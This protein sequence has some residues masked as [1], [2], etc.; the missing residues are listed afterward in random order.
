MVTVFFAVDE[1]RIG[2][3]FV[4]AFGS[5]DG[6]ITAVVSRQCGVE[7]QLDGFS[8]CTANHRGDDITLRKMCLFQFLVIALI[9]QNELVE[10]CRFG[11]EGRQCQHPVSVVDVQNLGNRTKIVSWI[12]FAVSGQIVSQAVMSVF[13]SVSDLIPQI[14]LISPGAVNYLTEN[15]LFYHI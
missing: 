15:T 2:S 12:I 3:F 14:M 11:S 5:T 1:D 7:S 6:K 8:V 4:H 10:S 13:F 9:L